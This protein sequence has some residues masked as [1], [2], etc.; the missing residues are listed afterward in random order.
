MARDVIGKSLAMISNGTE[1]DA[2]L[3]FMTLAVNDSG[4]YDCKVKVEGQIYQT[5]C[6]LTVQDNQNATEVT[7]VPST[8]Q[9]TQ[10]ELRTV[11]Q[12]NT[13]T[14]ENSTSPTKGKSNTWLQ[15]V[16]R[17]RHRR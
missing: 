10:H 14:G 12:N 1:G 2:S 5:V 4:I 13:N 8:N 9:E 3:R 11:Q 17:I 16:D 6:N 7:S 15:N